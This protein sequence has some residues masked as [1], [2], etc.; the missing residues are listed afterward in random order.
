MLLDAIVAR[1]L[2]DAFANAKRQV[3]S[4]MCGVTLLKVLDD[5]QRVQVVVEAP[6]VTLEA[7]VQCTLAGM[8]KRRMADVVNQ[9]QRLR[10]IFVQTKRGRGP[11]SDLRHLNRVGQAA[12]KVVGRAAGKDLRLACKPPEGASLHDALPITLEGRTRGA[13]R[14]R[15][16]AGQQEIVRISGDRASMEIDCHIRF[17]CNGRD[18]RRLSRRRD[19]YCLP[20]VPALASFTRAFSSLC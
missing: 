6:P 4:A 3:Q 2:D 11:T 7:A 12:A 20:G 13:G 9:R 10:Q 15:I 16:D 19:R 18:S 17:K 8:S 5:A 14:R 1:V